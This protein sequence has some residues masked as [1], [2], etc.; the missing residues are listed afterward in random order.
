MRARAFAFRA[1]AGSGDS[2]LH[3]VKVNVLSP[4]PYLFWFTVAGVRDIQDG[5][6]AQVIV[7]YY[8]LK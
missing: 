4:A 7:C 2:L 8:S 5:T 6:S 1:G 3:A